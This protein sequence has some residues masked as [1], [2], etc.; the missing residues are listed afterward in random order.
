MKPLCM[1]TLGYISMLFH[2]LNINQPVP[3]FENQFILFYKDIEPESN[4]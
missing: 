3:L 4:Y 1:L 2:D